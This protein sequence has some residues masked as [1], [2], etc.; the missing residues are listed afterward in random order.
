MICTH[1]TCMHLY[2]FL[3]QE[4]F[5]MGILQIINIYSLG[6]SSIEFYGMYLWINIWGIKL[7]LVLSIICFN[8]QRT[9]SP[10]KFCF[11]K[12]VVW[13]RFHTRISICNSN[14]F[15]HCLC[16]AMQLTVLITALVGMILI[17]IISPPWSWQV[18]FTVIVSW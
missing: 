8:I 13:Y 15:Q 16:V 12:S 10:V 17:K 7:K 18:Y 2:M 4:L 9:R 5:L 11:F 14:L 6:V 1:I 3:S